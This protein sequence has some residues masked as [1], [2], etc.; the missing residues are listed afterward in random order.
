MRRTLQH[1]V[2]GP[3]DIVANPIRYERSTISDYAAAPGLGEHSDAVLADWLDLASEDI[4]ALRREA[5]VA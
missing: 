1:P 4:A 3:V 5:V 2:A